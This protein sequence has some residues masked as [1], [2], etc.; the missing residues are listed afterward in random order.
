MCTCALDR[1]GQE[2]L[3]LEVCKDLDEGGDPDV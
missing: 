2:C 1:L 3:A